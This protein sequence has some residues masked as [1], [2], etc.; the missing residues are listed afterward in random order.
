MIVKVTIIVRWRTKTPEFFLP[1]TTF[2]YPAMWSKFFL[3]NIHNAKCYIFWDITPFS[4][5]KV[6][7]RFRGT[8]RLQLRVTCF[9]VCFLRDLFFDLENGPEIFPRMSVD[10]QRTTQCYIPG[11]ITRYHHRCENLKPYNIHNILIQIILFITRHA[12]VYVPYNSTGH[13]M[14]RHRSQFKKR[15]LRCL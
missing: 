2:L 14:D 15:W 8:R 6:N 3:N 9:Q 11:D 5:L 12:I 10:F 1:Y 13:L 4:P 7:R